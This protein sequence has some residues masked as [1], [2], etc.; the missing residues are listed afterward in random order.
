MFSTMQVPGT[1]FLLVF[2]IEFQSCV[3]AS[4]SLQLWGVWG[5][6]MPRQSLRLSHILLQ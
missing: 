1:E 2:A 3:R 5:M 6:Q 4:L